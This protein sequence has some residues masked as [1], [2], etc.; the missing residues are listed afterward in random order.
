MTPLE[1]KLG[2]RLPMREP[3]DDDLPLFGPMVLEPAATAQNRKAAAPVIPRPPALTDQDWK[4]PEKS[5]RGCTGRRGCYPQPERGWMYAFNEPEKLL[6]RLQVKAQEDTQ[7]QT[8]TLS[9]DGKI[10]NA[11]QIPFPVLRRFR[12]HLRRM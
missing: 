4:D 11:A 9:L 8:V 1:H 7:Q 12:L 2:Y 10:H 6:S 3:P 5:W